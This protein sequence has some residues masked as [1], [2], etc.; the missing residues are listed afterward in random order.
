MPDGTYSCPADDAAGVRVY[1]SYAGQS[2]EYVAINLTG[3]STVSAPGRDSR[4]RTNAISR[5]LR[6]A[7]PKAWQQY[8]GG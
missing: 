4:W 3:C 8:L 1:L 7:A 5:S 2:D 6:S